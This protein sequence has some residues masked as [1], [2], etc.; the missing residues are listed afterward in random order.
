MSGTLRDL[1]VQQA[2]LAIV[3]QN[4]NGSMPP[5]HNGPY[6][7]PESPLRNTCHWLVLWCHAHQWTED[8]RFRDASA[9]ALTY[10]FDPQHR[11]H[12]ANWLQRNTKHRDRCNGLIGAAWVIE[13]LA[14]ASQMLNS[15]KALLRAQEVFSLHPFVEKLGMWRRVEVDGTLLTFD[16]TFNHQLWFAASAARLAAAGSEQAARC[17]KSFLDRANCIFSVG[18]GGQIVHRI[19]L[20]WWDRLL[21]PG[22]PIHSAYIRF[23]QVRRNAARPLEAEK[24][25]VGYHAFSLHAFAVLHRLYPSHEFWHTPDFC[26]ALAFARSERHLAGIA[27][28]NPYAYPYNPVGF[29][30]ALTLQEFFPD[31]V[32]ERRAWV[33]R[34]ISAMTQHGSR[35]YGQGVDDPNTGR[36]RLYEAVGLE[37]I[38]L[39]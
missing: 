17:V 12:G 36:A 29:E 34:Q 7:H 30:M 31:A 11:P 10:I 27:Q 16:R 33:M 15:K 20:Y 14:C 8:E 28:D 39:R 21:E 22:S 38:S 37:P 13:A 35:A 25:D 23:D 26:D 2:V 6:F 4:D 1:L 5:G 19:R 18:P 9:R 24:R 32:E 3:D